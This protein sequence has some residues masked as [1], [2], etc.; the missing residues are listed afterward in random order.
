MR[1]Q[2]SRVHHFSRVVWMIPLAGASLPAQAQLLE[3]IVVTAQKREQNLQDVPVSVT[4]FTGDQL[5]DLRITNTDDVVD[6]TPGLTVFYP[7]AEGNTPNF[8]LRGVSSTDITTLTEAPIAVYTDEIYYGTQFGAIAQVYDMERYEA[9]R[10]PQGTLF[11]RNATGGLL[12]F[13]TRKPVFDE[14]GGYAEIAFGSH[15]ETTFEGA[16]NFALSDD[17]AIRLSAATEKYDGYVHNRFPGQRDPSDTDKIAARFQ[18]GYEGDRS[19]LNVNLHSAEDDSLVG[20]WQLVGAEVLDASG[21]VI[22]PAQ[23]STGQTVVASNGQTLLFDPSDVNPETTVLSNPM[24]LMGEAFT[25]YAE[26]IAIQGVDTRRAP[27]NPVNFGLFGGPYIDTDNDPFA[28]EYNYISDLN[29]EN[30]GAWVRYEYDIGDVMTFIA[31][32]G[33]EEFSQI[34]LEDTDLSPVDDIRAHFGGDNEQS[35]L[36]L[37]IEGSTDRLPSYVFG[38]YYYDRDVIDDRG[39]NVILPTLVENVGINPPL[40]S[41][42]DANTESV[43]I[44]GQVDIAVRDRLTLTAGLRYTDEETT[45]ISGTGNVDFCFFANVDRTACAAARQNTFLNGVP[46]ADQ[47]ITI[48]L[49]TWQTARPTPSNSFDF[50]SPQPAGPPLNY[51]DPNYTQQTNRLADDF[52]T[53]VLKLAYAL[54]DDSMVYA[55]YS[56]GSKS[57]GFNSN[58]A[59]IAILGTNVFS[60]ERLDSLEFGYRS[61][62]S[63]GR[64][65]FNATVFDYDYKDYQ[66]T[67][68]LAPGVSGT[69][70]S[71][72]EI[73]G[74]EVEFW[75][76][77][78]EKWT[79]FLASSFMFDTSVDNIRDTLGIVKT[80]EV[81][82]APDFQLNGFIEYVTRAWGG[83]LSA[84]LNFVYSDEYFSFLNN[85]GGGLVPSYD[86]FGASLGWRSASD[87]W[88]WRLNITNLTDENILVSAFDFSASSAYVQE[89]YQPPRWVS[90][91]FGVNF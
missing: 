12:H 18:I 24:N 91:N 67:Q 88:Y 21:N 79:I 25:A 44:F 85:L 46:L 1:S 78:S 68:F 52:S 53:G 86:K 35:S 3:E 34:Y 80:R 66:A 7:L 51:V 10:G 43:A 6:F 39:P 36:E 14:T 48:D 71:D 45:V 59:A 63:E 58:P 40:H 17:W 73:T 22:V 38:A 72:A 70:N 90:L 13:V 65:R 60:R 50:I 89:L 75:V 2:L 23:D 26:S 74:A 61:E 20:A 33:V 15:N 41:D 62:F 27:A 76:A 77:P 4:A 81:K 29:I 82:Q 84:Q 56:Q 31:L 19:R 47:G 5:K 28:G 54:S 16:V 42:D 8:S 57:G 30:T 87:S 9:L 83:D 11:G 37:R 69:A 64:M 55:S 32:G 49:Q